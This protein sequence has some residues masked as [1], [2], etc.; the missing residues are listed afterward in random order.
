MYLPDLVLALDGEVRIHARFQETASWSVLAILV[1]GVNCIRGSLWRK[2]CGLAI[3]IHLVE[4]SF[5]LESERM[6]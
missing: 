1:D 2:P 6:D 3:G 4:R 5:G